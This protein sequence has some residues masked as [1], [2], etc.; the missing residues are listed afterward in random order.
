MQTKKASINKRIFK[1]YF[2]NIKIVLKGPVKETGKNELFFSEQKSGFWFSSDLFFGSLLIVDVKGGV[3]V[4][5]LK[6]WGFG[7]LGV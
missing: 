3:R 5:G 7:G 4:T 2:K 1:R 6:V